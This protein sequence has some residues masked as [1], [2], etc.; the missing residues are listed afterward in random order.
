VTEERSRSR[1]LSVAERVTRSKPFFFSFSSTKNF[2]IYL[3][4][5]LSPLLLRSFPTRPPETRKRRWILIGSSW[6]SPGLLL[7]AVA[8]EEEEEEEV[9]S[10]RTASLQRPSPTTPGAMMTI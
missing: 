3:S 6:R 9:R 2:P 10:L 7:T 1:F 4:A 5:F 8:E